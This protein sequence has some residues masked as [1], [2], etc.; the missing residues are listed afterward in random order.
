MKVEE[1]V[2]KCLRELMELGLKKVTCWGDGWSVVAC[3][4]PPSAV[5]GS[6]VIRIDVVVGEVKKGAGEGGEG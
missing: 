2:L 5:G 6:G 1:A 4:V 3:R